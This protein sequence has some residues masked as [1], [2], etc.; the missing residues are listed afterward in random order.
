MNARL[1]VVAAMFLFGGPALF[2]QATVADS[3]LKSANGLYNAGSYE[4][5]E[6]AA[7][8]LMEQGP[9]ADSIRVQ[10]E[11]I[12]AFS[13]VA[14]G[15]TELAREH[16]ET[17][18]AVSPSFD[19]DPVLTSPKIL[20]VFREAKLH[21]AAVR[22]PQ[23]SADRQDK[24]FLSGIT[25]RTVLFPGWEQLHQG[26]TTSGVIFGGAGLLTLGSA[27]TFEAFR[28]PARKDYLAA[29]QPA[30][31]DAKYKLYNRYY[32]GEVYSFIAFAAVYVASELD[33]FLNAG[34]P[35]DVQS[36]ADDKRGM[37]LSFALHW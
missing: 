28:L 5:A 33:V 34:S 10:A 23:Q 35:I 13:L 20:A 24:T 32:R 18:L 8:R 27:L 37:A 36:S 29:T 3:A 15:K 30:D 12:I 25:F 11:R 26:R 21:F 31:I 17:I 4:S 9:I 1:L 19:L 16:F 2:G 22:R 6:L 7:R 14:Q